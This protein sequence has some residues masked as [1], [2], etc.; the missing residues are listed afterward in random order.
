MHIKLITKLS[1]VDPQKNNRLNDTKN[2]Q[3]VL[4]QPVWGMNTARTG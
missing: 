3:N 4:I 2:K 1:P